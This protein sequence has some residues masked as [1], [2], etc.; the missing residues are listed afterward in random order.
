[1]GAKIT[2]AGGRRYT[3][4]DLDA[5][6]VAYDA[7]YDYSQRNEMQYKDYFRLDLSIKYRINAKNIGHEF[8]LDLVNVLNTKNFF[9]E[10]YNPV[11]KQGYTETQLGFLP[12]FYYRI[13]F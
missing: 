3:P 13:D 11:L 2:W 9:K 1:M 6:E 12:I 4:I 8:G 7:V 10:E 5:S